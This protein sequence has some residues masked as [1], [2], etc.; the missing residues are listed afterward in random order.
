MEDLTVQWKGLSLSHREGPKF[1][2]NSDLASAEYTIAAK[3]LTKRALNTDAIAATFKPLWRSKNGFR[4]KNLGNH[5]VLFIFDNEEE[6]DTIMA[7]EPWSFDKHLMVLQ[8]YG[9]DSIVEELSF[10]LTQFWVQVH[11]IPLGFMNPTVAAGICETA[12][13]VSRNPKMPIEDGG[14]FMRVRVLIDI[15]QPL[16]RGRVICLEDDKELWVSFKYERLPNLCY[17]C[18]RLTHSD[19]DCD[20]W[21]DS[22]GTLEETDKKYGPWLRAQPFASSRK[23]VVTVP[24]F[25]VKN[26]DTS[27]AGKSDGLAGRSPE[28]DTFLKR[29]Q[30]TSQTNKENAEPMEAVIANSNDSF[31]T[32]NGQAGQDQLG[33]DLAQSQVHRDT[34]E[35][36]IEEIDRELSKFDLPG[37]E[38]HVQNMVFDDTFPSHTPPQSKLP[39]DNPYATPQPLHN[40]NNHAEP[41][42]NPNPIP[43][44]IHTP[45][46]TPPTITPPNTTKNISTPPHFNTPENSSNNQPSSS[47]DLT[48][49]KH[50]PIITR[51]PQYTTPHTSPKPTSPLHHTSNED[52]APATKNRAPNASSPALHT[53]NTAT[54]TFI[55]PN[56][57]INNP[58]PSPLPTSKDAPIPPA[59]N[60]TPN[61]PPL[62]WPLGNV[63]QELEHKEIR[64]RINHRERNVQPLSTHISLSYQV[65]SIWFLKLIMKTS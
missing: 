52:S 14:G 28:T 46:I 11:G 20:L 44:P 7:N 40:L 15:T 1:R 63:S 33:P 27:K 12:G 18:G 34:L 56:T 8:R 30:E 26:T 51:N 65:R 42:Q 64:A 49:A 31:L 36:Q 4:V 24:G 32:Q 35:K 50:H 58:T 16:C 5:V 47:F 29:S 39:S 13:T 3:F 17:W 45:Q 61:P 41:Q 38:L 9:K 43:A 21:L 59:K 55:P 57:T 54:S 62:P 22:E 48:H 53:P 10:N 23:I 25:Y 6:V 2:L 60:K 19:R 37:T